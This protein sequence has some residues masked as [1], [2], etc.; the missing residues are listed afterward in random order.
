MVELGW[1]DIMTKVSCLAAFLAMPHHGHFDAVFHMF[2][3]LKAHSRSCLAFDPTPIDYSQEENVKHDWEA[4][5]GLM[6]E[7]WPPGV[8]ELLGNTVQMM[9]LL[10]QTTQEIRLCDDQGWVC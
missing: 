7:P 6:K 2:S 1:I 3:Y 8:P 10:I 5:Y 9:A 4:F